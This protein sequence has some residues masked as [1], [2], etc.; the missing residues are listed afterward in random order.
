MEPTDATALER[1]LRLCMYLTTAI[2]FP[3]NIAATVLSI[4]FQRRRWAPR[5]VTAYCFAYIPLA[6]TVVAASI[7]L[8]YMKKHNKIPK[9]L[10]YRIFDLLAVCAY[11]AVLIPCWALEIREFS[12]G[13][14]G[15]LTGYLTA[16]MIINL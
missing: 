12:A 15:L 10:S 5:D 1:P 6:L 4:R 3:L 16:P 11:I 14:F 9:S 2:A 7:S 13:G 8:R